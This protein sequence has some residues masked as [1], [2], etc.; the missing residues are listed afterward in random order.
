M[1]PRSPK[2]LPRNADDENKP[3]YKPN[4]P[5][6][7]SPNANGVTPGASALKRSQDWPLTQDSSAV[8]SDAYPYRSEPLR[9]Y[10]HG[11][12]KGLA[13]YSPTSGSKPEILLQGVVNIVEGYRDQWPL[14]SRQIM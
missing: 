12:P 11:R 6:L 7:S 9:E 3:N 4:N 2:D 5:R 10:P 13:P 14:T 1:K 8:M